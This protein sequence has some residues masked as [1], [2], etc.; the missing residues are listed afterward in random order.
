VAPELSEFAACVREGR[1]PEPS[2]WEGLADVRV[3]DAVEAA[4]RSG[5]HIR[6]HTVAPDRRPSM[7]QNRKVRGRRKPEAVNVQAPHQE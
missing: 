2:G 1:D 5:E 4:L 7:R 3:I 6:V